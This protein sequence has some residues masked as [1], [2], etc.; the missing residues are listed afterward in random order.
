[1]KH[2]A[3]LVV[4]VLIWAISWPVVKIGVAGL[5]PLW[6]AC[7]RCLIAAL[8]LFAFVGARGALAVPPRSD[9]PLVAVSAALQLAAYPALTGAAL[10]VL[11]AGR[12]SVLAYSTPLWVL[13]LG[14]WWLQE[15]M[16][17]SGL[18]G[19]SLGVAGALAIAYPS[20][21]AA[22]S[23]ELLAYALLVGAA[24]VWSVSIVFVR[25]HRFTATPLAL[26]PWQMLIATSLLLPVALLIEGAPPSIA[27]GV[28]ASLAY[29]GP[30]ATAFAYWAVVELGRRF[31]ATTMSMAL[32]AVP[33]LGILI[34]AMTIGEAVGP[35]LIAG[36]LL[37]GTG[38]QL[39]TLA[40]KQAA[41]R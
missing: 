38:I 8:C 31:R 20:L 26:A 22:G 23:H 36:V 12:A 35:S 25:A 13:P 21:H 37:I 34:S 18:V 28:A 33:G 5:P 15:R 39:T 9:W 3:L 32:L 40:G 17:P 24:G 19:V 7:F 2:R 27:P 16:T 41:V 4:L 14:S 10:T 29:V 1:M 30:V 11:P 6:Y